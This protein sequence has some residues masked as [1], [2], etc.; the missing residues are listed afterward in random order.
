MRCGIKKHELMF[1]T[2]DFRSSGGFAGLTIPAFIKPSHDSIF[3]NTI[4]GCHYPP[5]L[6]L[7]FCEL[8]HPF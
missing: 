8:L 1:T 2:T 5:N 7:R 4:K 6:R 3:R